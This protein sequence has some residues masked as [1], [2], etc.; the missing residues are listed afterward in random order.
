MENMAAG[1]PGSQSLASPDL[2]AKLLDHPRAPL[3]SISQG[4][5]P[6][7][8]PACHVNAKTSC[9]LAGDS[10]YLWRQHRWGSCPE[11]G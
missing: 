4:Y 3:W 11:L 5:I 7:P 2:I 1:A 6:V 10:L 9:S 8:G